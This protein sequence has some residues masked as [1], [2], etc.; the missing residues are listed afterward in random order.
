MLPTLPRRQLRVM[1]M[2]QPGP[3]GDSRGPLGGNLG[4]QPASGC[5]ASSTLRHSEHFLA[6]SPA[7]SIELEHREAYTSHFQ[8]T[9]GQYVP[10]LEPNRSFGLSVG[11]FF[12]KAYRLRTP[13]P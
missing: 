13:G 9:V 11:T 2:M 8:V 12:W 4:W 3:F 6:C 7:T 1:W 5:R 10:F